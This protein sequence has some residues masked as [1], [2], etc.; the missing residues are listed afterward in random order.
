MTSPAATRH[1]TTPGSGYANASWRVWATTVFLGVAD[2]SRLAPARELVEHLLSELDIAISRFRDDSDLLRANA[3]AGQWVDVSPWLVEA[4]DVA[5]RVAEDTGGLVDPT[6]GL[7][8]QRLG[9]DDDLDVVRSRAEATDEPTGGPSSPPGPADLPQPPL[10]SAA[11]RRVQTAPGR[12]RVPAGSA[13]DLGATGKAFAA[14]RVAAVVAERIG[15]DCILSIGGDVAVAATGRNRGR[16]RW[17][18]AV[19]ERPGE[20]ARQVVD[21]PHGAVATSTIVHRTWWQDGGFMH[22]LL[23][24]ATGLPVR[25]RWRTATVRADDCVSANAASTA[26]LVLGE[27]AADWLDARRLA[28]RLVDRDGTVVALGDWPTDGLRAGSGEGSVS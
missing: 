28:A 10:I 27:R 1:R 24:P 14:D 26:A 5:V 21:L 18:V 15:T 25:H 13:L 4:A 2:A 7:H 9:Y 19:S 23:D 11:W 20:A 17:R 3:A 8:L 22:H 16:H 12:L 6:M